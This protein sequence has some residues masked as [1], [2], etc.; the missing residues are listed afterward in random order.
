MKGVTIG[1]IVHYVSRDYDE[2]PG[3]IVK[4]CTNSN[5]FAIVN[6][7]VFSDKATDISPHLGE[8]AVNWIRTVPYNED[9]GSHSWH[10]IER[11]DE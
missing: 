9:K 4:V 1:R 5:D 3:I 11:E 7:Q 8:D 6:L 10:W 2:Y